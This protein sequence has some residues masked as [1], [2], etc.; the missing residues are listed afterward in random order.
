MP[1]IKWSEVEDAGSYTPVPDGQYLC[2]LEDVTE[3][4]GPK[5]EYWN[6]SWKII[7]GINGEGKGD[8]YQNH[9]IFDRISFS[10]PALKRTKLVCS[11]LGLQLDDDLEL[12]PGDLRGKQALI[13]AT[14]ED[15]LDDS[16][17][18]KQRNNVP[19]DGYERIDA[20]GVSAGEESDD[21]SEESTPF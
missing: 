7:E 11:R 12:T 3:K 21:A 9:I 6:L 16:E 20:V 4:H 19:F 5:G 18:Q 8:Q 14:I 13:T 10:K 2:R 15:Y 1:K 17:Q